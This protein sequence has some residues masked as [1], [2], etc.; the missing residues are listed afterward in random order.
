MRRFWNDFTASYVC[1]GVL[2][3]L[4]FVVFLVLFAL[5]MRAAHA[6]TF[7]GDPPSCQH[8]AGYAAHAAMLRDE[9][10]QWS[11][12]EPNIRRKIAESRASSNKAMYV[13]DQQDEDY[14]IETFKWVFESAEEPNDVAQMVM[15]E[16]MTKPKQAAKGGGKHKKA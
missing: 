14:V 13:K 2:A 7:R 5:G 12:F 6:E 11:E 1:G 8:L 16:C 3:I 15:R 9:G 10:M 4:L